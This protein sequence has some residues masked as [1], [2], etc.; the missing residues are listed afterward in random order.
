M[1]K[2][3]IIATVSVNQIVKFRYTDVDGETSYRHIHVDKPRNGLTTHP[4]ND[5]VTYAADNEKN[6]KLNIV[7]E[8]QITGVLVQVSNNILGNAETQK[9]KF[10]KVRYMTATIVSIA[11]AAK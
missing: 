3:Q 9:R 8:E 5:C 4:D 1:D 10:G 2:A 11:A 7:G 6:R